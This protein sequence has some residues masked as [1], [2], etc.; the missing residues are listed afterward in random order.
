MY[1]E[2]RVRMPS[3]VMLT[4]FGRD[5]EHKDRRWMKLADTVGVEVLPVRVP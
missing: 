4:P 5:E 3:I 2:R 1:H